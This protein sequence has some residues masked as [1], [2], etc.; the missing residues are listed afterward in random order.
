MATILIVEDEP[1]NLKVY[2]DSVSRVEQELGLLFKHNLASNY[3]EAQQVLEKALNEPEERPV[4][5]LLDMEIPRAGHKDKR[6]GYKLMKEYRWKFDD[7]YWIPLTAH[8]A[9]HEVGPITTRSLFDELYHLQPFDVFAKGSSGDLRDVVC[10]ALKVVQAAQEYNLD[11]DRGKLMTISDTVIRFDG[12]EYL[13]QPYIVYYQ[14]RSAAET[15]RGI[16]LIGQPGVWK[17]ITRRERCY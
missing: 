11:S 5:V 16:L 14:I 6:G 3:E 2:N 15:A 8:V 13:S 7:T 1:E 17:R 12:E 4:L 9:W 10:R